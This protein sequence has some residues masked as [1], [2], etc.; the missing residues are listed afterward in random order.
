M[1][2][3]TILLITFIIVTLTAS[4]QITT[5]IIKAGFG[6]DAHYFLKNKV[7]FR[8]HFRKTYSSTFF[9]MNRENALLRRRHRRRSA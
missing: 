3:K 1:P 9:D 4:A 6:V 7:D 5:P 8:A 2:M